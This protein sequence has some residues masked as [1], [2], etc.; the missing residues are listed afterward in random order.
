[1]QNTTLPTIIDV[2]ASGFGA[3]SYPIEIGIVRYDGAKWCKLLRP[4]DSWVHWDTKAQSL[5]GISQQMLQARGEEPHKVC[6][7]LNNF[8]GNTVVYSDGW[9]VDNPWLIKLYS[10]AQIDMSFT[11]RALEYILTESQMDNWHDVKNS[12]SAELDV[13]R[14][15]ASSDAMI[16][17]QTYAKT[18]ALTQK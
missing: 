18:M 5:H 7:E 4:F 13:K 3:A 10:A 11:C 12:L 8:L 9:V 2:E 15:R 14:H 6:V 17:Q 16:I 1:M